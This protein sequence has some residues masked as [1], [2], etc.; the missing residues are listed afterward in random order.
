MISEAE[1][2]K[3][4]G[5]RPEQRVFQNM[6]HGG[7]PVCGIDMHA[8]HPEIDRVIEPVVKEALVAD[9]PEREGE[10]GTSDGIQI[11]PVGQG[12]F[13]RGGGHGMKEVA[14]DQ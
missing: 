6:A 12:Q 10:R 13:K 9:R 4:E 2:R 7:R 14:R 1:R 8:V 11:A 3:F 5:Q